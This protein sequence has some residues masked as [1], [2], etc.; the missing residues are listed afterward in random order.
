M[1]VEQVVAERQRHRRAADEVAAD[2]ERLGDALGLG[3]HG[4]ADAEAELAAVAEQAPEAVWSAGVVITR[5]S[6]MPASISVDRG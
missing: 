3:L 6:R 1:A 2:E 5:I 4:I